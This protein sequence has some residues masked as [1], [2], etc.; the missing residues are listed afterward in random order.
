[1]TVLDHNKN[2]GTANKTG[3][4]MLEELAALSAG[5]PFNMGADEKLKF[6]KKAEGVIMYDPRISELILN[7]PELYNKYIDEELIS[8]WVDEVYRRTHRLFKE[9]TAVFVEAAIIPETFDAAPLAP[10]VQDAKL[11]NR[12]VTLGQFVI[13]DPSWSGARGWTNDFDWAANRTRPWT[14]AD[15]INSRYLVL[16]FENVPDGNLD[17]IWLGDSNDWTWK[18][19]SVKPAGNTLVID[20]R[21]IEDY[22]LYVRCKVI[23]IYIGY[24]SWEE[25]GLKDAYFA[26]AKG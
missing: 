7:T 4:D 6:P 8:D 2:G 16:E 26:D 10:P 19:T 15:F 18:Q 12:T 9:R 13:T 23:K 3:K 11:Y 22:N 21:Q 1:V 20:L 14:A 25:L 5:A 17:F 24:Y